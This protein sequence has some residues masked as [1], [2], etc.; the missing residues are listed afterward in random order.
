MASTPM[1]TLIQKIVRQPA[2]NQFASIS[3]PASTGPP[4]ADRPMTGPKAAKALPISSAGNT[5]LMMAKPCGIITAPS[6]PWAT[7]LPISISGEVARPQTVE[8]TVK[9]TAPIRKSRRRPT[10]SPR[11]PKVIRPMANASV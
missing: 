2:S 4:T 11:R 1:G 3:T 6:R 5:A 9:P 8:A 7:R 10:R